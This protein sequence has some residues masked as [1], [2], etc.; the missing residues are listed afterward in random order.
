MVAVVLFQ[1]FH[2]GAGVPSHRNVLHLL[3]IF[4]TKQ[5][6]DVSTWCYSPVV[7]PANAWRESFYLFCIA[8]L[9]F[10]NATLLA[11]LLGLCV[12]RNGC[13]CKGKG[14]DFHQQVLCHFIIVVV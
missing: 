14:G 3:A 8:K 9:F 12:N 2:V 4:A 13:K 5:T 11:A 7:C 1:L 6:L 10:C